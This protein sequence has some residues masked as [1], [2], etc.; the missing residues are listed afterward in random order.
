MKWKRERSA[1]LSD[2]LFISC[3]GEYCIQVGCWKWCGGEEKSL[4]LWLALTI[5]KL[6]G[7]TAIYLPISSIRFTERLDRVQAEMLMMLIFEAIDNYNQT[8]MAI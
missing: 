6:R 4:Y 8:T 1:K 2:Y 3:L 7:P 5:N